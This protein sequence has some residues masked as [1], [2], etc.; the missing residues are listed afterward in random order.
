[1]KLGAWDGM[2]AWD[3]TADIFRPIGMIPSLLG[4]P[5]H[6]AFTL[7]SSWL[8]SPIYLAW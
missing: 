8:S 4:H 3:G 5:L 1:M 7:V 2:G 6:T